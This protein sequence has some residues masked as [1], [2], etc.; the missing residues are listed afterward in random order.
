MALLHELY[1]SGKPKELLEKRNGG[2]ETEGLECSDGNVGRGRKMNH[3][4][5]S[6]A[7]A[8]LLWQTEGASREEE[9]TNQKPKDLNAVMSDGNVGLGQTEG[10]ECMLLYSRLRQ[11]TTPAYLS[12]L[13][14]NTEKLDPSVE[15]LL[16]R[17]RHT[18]I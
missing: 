10:L 16:S 7:R 18:I 15:P 6:T 4:N 13:Y 9:M 1:F 3:W 2:S 11:M 5:A 14:M 17:R 12:T 8:V